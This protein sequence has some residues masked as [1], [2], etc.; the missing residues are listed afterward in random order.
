MEGKENRGRLISASE[1]EKWAYC[2]LSWKLSREFSTEDES[3]RAGIELHR[4]VDEDLK[5]SIKLRRRSSE[6]YLSFYV[7]ASTFLLLF[8]TGIVLFMLV[9]TGH[10]ENLVPAFTAASSVFLILS[11]FTLFRTFFKGGEIKER[12]NP[13][14]SISAN[15]ALFLTVTF[16]LGYCGYLKGLFITLTG[17]LIWYL[18]LIG[19]I[20]LLSL[21]KKKFPR[22]LIAIIRISSISIPVVVLL[23]FFEFHF[24]LTAS[25]LVLLSF[26]LFLASSALL[27]HVRDLGYGDKPPLA[28]SLKTPEGVA[29]VF[30]SSAVIFL[31]LTG[32]LS[33]EGGITIYHNFLLD[34]SFAWLIIAGALAAAGAYHS[35]SS[36]RL[37]SW[38]GGRVV[39]QSL[40][41][42]RGPL[43]KSTTLGISGRPDAIVVEGGAKVPVEI[44]YGRV[45]RGP[46]FSHIMQLAAYLY[47]MR[48]GEGKKPSYGYIRY[49]PREGEPRDFRVDWSEELEELLKKF[50]GEI[51]EAEE[52]LREVHRN[53]RRKGKCLH[54]SRR[55]SCPERL[56]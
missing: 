25:Y 34:L 42:G 29:A 28:L 3:L 15:A 11:L 50:V 30:L 8:I 21:L 18:M 40:A 45:P 33:T 43:L 22:F 10:V 35:M 17:A 54:C 55:E 44:K 47:V 14:V 52:G 37:T 51:R 46:F 38:V 12:L 13:S 32:F 9:R 41:S 56:S 6:E 23:A 16:V 4:R 1:I 39:A 31:A 7:G 20:L 2:P 27:W 26:L 53:H 24:L 48:E 5:S 49:V 36:Q 19:T